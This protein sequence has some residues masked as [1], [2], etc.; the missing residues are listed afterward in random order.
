[1][2]YPNAD[3]AGIIPY[4]LGA[5]GGGISGSM[6]SIGHLGPAGAAVLGMSTVIELERQYVELEHH[7]RGYEE[8]VERTDRLLGS[9]RKALEEVRGAIV[10]QGP[11]M[12]SSSS[13]SP[14]RQEVVQQNQSQRQG[15]HEQQQQHASGQDGQDQQQQ[16]QQAQPQSH[17]QKDHSH[18]ESAPIIR[19]DKNTKKDGAAAPTAVWRVDSPSRD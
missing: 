16:Q 10:P 17:A 15:G 7:K 18:P 4:G 6:G 5:L 9:V 14:P 1:V 2:F 8:M 19:T 11:T 3:Q 12:S 13:S